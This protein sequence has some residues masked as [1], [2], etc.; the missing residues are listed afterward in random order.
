M[1]PAPGKRDH[2]VIS[3]LVI[4]STQ[5]DR[6]QAVVTVSVDIDQDVAHKL[7]QHLQALIRGGARFIVIDLS[8]VQ[9][10]DDVVPGLLSWTQHRLTDRNGMISVVGL[11]PGVLTANNRHV[12]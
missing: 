10:C 9:Q 3:Q 12:A 1:G 2:M 4:S 6:G 11:A 8:D 7:R 5:D